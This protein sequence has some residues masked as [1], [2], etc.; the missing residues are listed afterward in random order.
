MKTRSELIIADDIGTGRSQRTALDAVIRFL[1]YVSLTS[2]R[3]HGRGVLTHA[4]SE[5]IFS[6]ELKMIA[7]CTIQLLDVMAAHQHQFSLLSR[8]GA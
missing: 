8:Y 7:F 3:I 6:L 2:Y 5:I 1:L 4:V